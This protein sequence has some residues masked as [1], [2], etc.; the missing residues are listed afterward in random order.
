M[1]LLIFTNT[2]NDYNVDDKINIFVDVNYNFKY[3]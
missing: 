1:Y 3:R 2:D